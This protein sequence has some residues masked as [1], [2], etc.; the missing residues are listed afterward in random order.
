MDPGILIHTAE[1]TIDGRPYEV[2]VYLRSDG[3]HIARTI[4]SPGDVII[5]DGP[6]LEEVLAKHQRLLPLAVDSRLMLSE[7]RCSA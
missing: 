6:S 3:S 1:L 5:H 7:L 4:F 2:T